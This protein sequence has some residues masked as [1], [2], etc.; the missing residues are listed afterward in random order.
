MDNLEQA[1]KHIRELEEEFHNA[2]EQRLTASHRRIIHELQRDWIGTVLLFSA[3]VF[4][5]TAASIAIIS[6]KR[7]Y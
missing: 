5:L 2:L 1:Q 6:A 4:G 7:N 3:V